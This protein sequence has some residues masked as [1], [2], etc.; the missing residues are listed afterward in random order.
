MTTTALTSPGAQGGPRRKAEAIKNAM[1][2]ET[3]STRKR[4]SIQAV[5]DALRS[6]TDRGEKDFRVPKVAAAIARLGLTGP[7]EQSI[8]NRE[9][10][11]FRT[12]IAAYAEEHGQVRRPSGDEDDDLALAIGDP[13]VAARVRAVL[14]QNRALKHRND[15]LHQQYAKLVDRPALP[16]PAAA[17]DAAGP[18][19][20]AD[21]ARAVAAFLRALDAQ[22]WREDRGTGA[23]LDHRGSE[24]APPYFAD[25]LRKVVG[26]PQ[27]G[28]QGG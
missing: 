10:E 1:L 19:L 23:I 3:E 12:L 22:G 28:P 16:A 21:E 17:G 26:L 7:K 14:A 8:R 9:G 18:G 27:G 24:I 4:K 20:S 2:A 15:L 5:W 6:M 11:S 13:K 25:A